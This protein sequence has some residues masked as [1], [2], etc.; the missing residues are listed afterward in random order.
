M[1]RDEARAY[2]EALIA[3]GVNVRYQCYEGTIHGFFCFCGTI[4][5]GRQALYNLCEYLQGW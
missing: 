4:E 5:P 2:G 3:A 1:L